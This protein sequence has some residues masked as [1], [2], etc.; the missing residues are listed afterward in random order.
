MRCLSHAPPPLVPHSA[1]PE[2]DAP[3][4]NYPAT[5][6]YVFDEESSIRFRR[7]AKHLG[8][9][10]NDLLVRD[11]FLALAEWRSR[12]DIE[13]GA[14]WLRMAVP[15][16]LRTA[17]DH[18]LPAA[19][20]AAA[21]FLDRRGTDFADAGQLLRSVHKDLA[22][23]KQWRLGLAFIF[24]ANIGQLL[25]GGNE[26]KFRSDGHRTSSTLTNLGEPFAHLPVSDCDGRAVAGNMTLE[27]IEF[28]CP[29]TPWLRN[30]GSPI[31][32]GQAWPDPALRSA[33]IV[34]RTGGRSTRHVRAEDPDLDGRAALTIP[35]VAAFTYA[36]LQEKEFQRLGGSETIKA[37]VRIIAATNRNLE[38]IDA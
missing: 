28:A 4:K 23:V 36:V 21:R 27:D 14:P 33:T 8:V 25:N 3:P 12:Q 2:D 26:R 19:N 34:G 24:L 22:L 30:R 29:F 17:D 18:L 32:R 10:L 1:C 13:N 5:L 11:L 16:N 37:D 35:C 9:T 38:E 31:V 7:T 6:H 20:V 15:T